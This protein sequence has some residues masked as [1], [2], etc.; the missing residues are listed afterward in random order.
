MLKEI[1]EMVI[2][3]LKAFQFM[4]FLTLS[5]LWQYLITITTLPKTPDLC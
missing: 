2:F 3:V 4:R 5:I 1:F